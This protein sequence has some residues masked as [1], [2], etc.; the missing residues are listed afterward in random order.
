MKESFFKAIAV[1]AAIAAIGSIGW[2]V[3]DQFFVPDLNVNSSRQYY[4]EDYTMRTVPGGST[5]STYTG[6]SIDFIVNEGEKVYMTYTAYA[7]INQLSPTSS[8]I[9]FMFRLDGIRILQPTVKVG[10]YNDDNNTG[11]YFSVSLQH[12]NSSMSAG[13]HTLTITFQGSSSSDTVHEQTLYVEI[14]S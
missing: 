2:L 4:D 5:W 1:I 8:E 11:L 9:N 3:Y 14:F 6:L 12:F 13:S 10:K 7:Q